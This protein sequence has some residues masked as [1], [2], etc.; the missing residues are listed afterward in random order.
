V[1]RPVACWAGPFDGH[2]N[3]MSGRSDARLSALPNENTRPAV[4]I[5]YHHTVEKLVEVFKQQTFILSVKIKMF[6]IS[7]S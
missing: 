5:L 7:G 6:L 2:G 4:P 1:S 3:A